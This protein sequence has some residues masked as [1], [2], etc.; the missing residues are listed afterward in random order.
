MP[1]D[2]VSPDRAALND[3]P[4][5]GDP[6]LK[7][8]PF[9]G[10][11]A[12]LDEAESLIAIRCNGCTGTGM[13]TAFSPANRANAIRQWNTRAV[14]NPERTEAAGQVYYRTNN[15]AHIEL[16]EAGKDLI[17]GDTV[18]VTPQPLLRPANRLSG[19]AIAGMAVEIFG[20]PIPQEAYTLA[21]EIQDALLPH[22][23]KSKGPSE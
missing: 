12:W 11:P 20:N 16:T 21:N 15:Q 3:E 10:Q 7:D 6:D 8:C 13:I 9:C 4:F 17:E 1:E 22:T 2:T 5:T 23:A 14:E 19:L 18:F